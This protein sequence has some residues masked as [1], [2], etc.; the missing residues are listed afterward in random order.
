VVAVA[1]LVAW[2]Y[3]LVGAAIIMAIENPTR[4]EPEATSLYQ[5]ELSYLDGTHV[6]YLTID[7]FI[8]LHIYLLLIIIFCVKAHVIVH[9]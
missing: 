7:L 2:L 9:V 5:G 1:W 3:V 4:R 6:Y 8:H